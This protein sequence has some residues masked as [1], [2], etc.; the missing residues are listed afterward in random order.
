MH[1]FNLARSQQYIFDA[2]NFPIFSLRFVLEIL[3]TKNPASAAVMNAKIILPDQPFHD[4][5][6]SK[7]DCKRIL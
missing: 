2:V 1:P 3:A 4:F 7:S 5:E 6:T